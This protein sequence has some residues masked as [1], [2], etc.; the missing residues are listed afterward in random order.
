MYITLIYFPLQTNELPDLDKALDIEKK[1]EKINKDLEGLPKSFGL[2][3]ASSHQK[4][5]FK[6]RSLVFQ[7]NISF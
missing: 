2:E 6:F 4:G 3:G 7:V 5:T 1:N